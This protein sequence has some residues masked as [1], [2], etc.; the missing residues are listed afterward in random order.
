MFAVH[1]DETAH[2]IFLGKFENIK[3]Y[4]GKVLQEIIAAICA[5]LNSN[6]GKVVIHIG[7]DSKDIPVGFPFSQVALVIRILEQSMISIIGLHHT[8]SKINFRVDKDS[9]II[10]IKKADSLITTNYNLFLPSQTQVVMVSPVESPEHVKNDIMNRKIVPQPVQLGSHC[11]MFL[12][13]NECSFKESKVVAFK[14]LKADP[15]KRTTLADRMICKGNKFSCYVSAFANHNGGHIYYGITDYGVVEGEFIQN[16]KDKNEITKKVEKA[17]NTMIWPLQIGQPKRGV[18]WD[19]F[20]EPVLDE[21]PV[22]ST[23][24]IV[25]YIAPC[26]GGVFTEEPECYEMVEGQIKKMSFPTWKN[27]IS[28]P[29]WLHGREIPHSVQRITWSSPKARKAFIVDSE[30]LRQLISNGNWNAISKECEILQRKSH[31]PEMKLLVLSN[32]VTSCYRKGNFRT[33]RTLLDQYETILPEAPDVLIFEVL[34]LYLQA[35]LKRASGDSVKALEEPLNAA[36]S[37]TEL[38]EPGLVTATVYVF[39]GTVT[40]LI[41]SKNPTNKIDCPNVLSI[42]AL[43]H[44]QCVPDPSTVVA[45]MEQKAHITLATFYLSCN[46]SGQPS[47]GNVDISS[48]EKAETSIMAV[49]RSVCKGNTLTGYREAQFNLVQS[50]F[51]YR[52]SQVRPDGRVRF[53][54]NGFNFAKK[55]EYLAR[56]YQFTEMVQWS[57]ANKALC[58]EE[59]VRAK[60]ATSTK[61]NKL[62][63]SFPA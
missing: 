54:R 47:K 45:D 49:H 16:E 22:P 21:K 12:K 59:L 42:K 5:M 61:K 20:F 53:L 33:A 36:L 30:K 29:V 7:T 27:R 10:F 1:S 31:L 8:T 55:A 60:L 23:F 11:Q 37:K 24:V 40:D 34:G 4:K 50:I 19:I 25:I 28:R 38:I 39:A 62:C 6:G 46:I 56:E 3:R 17:I 43:E 2:V 14:C 51:S 63:V 41:N 32:R 9:I 58:T 15:S 35:A 48:L 52:H 44:L 18:H 13:D 57:D 26:W